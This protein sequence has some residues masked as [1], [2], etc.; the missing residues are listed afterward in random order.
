MF[1]FR[2]FMISILVILSTYTAITIQNDGWDL[3]S[4]FFGDM[5]KLS[6]PGQFNLDFSFLLLISGLWTLWKNNF[7]GAGIGLSLLAVFGGAL[8]LSPYLLY[9]SFACGGR[10]EMMLLPWEKQKKR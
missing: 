8:F 6:W 7:S 2:L 5:S 1:A 3:F 4:V 10:I 9:L